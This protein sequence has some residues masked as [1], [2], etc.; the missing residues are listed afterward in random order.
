MTI[1]PQPVA[2]AAAFDPPMLHEIATI[3]AE[4]MRAVSNLYRNADGSA[5]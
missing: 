1:F 2:L 3:I 4:E 5:R